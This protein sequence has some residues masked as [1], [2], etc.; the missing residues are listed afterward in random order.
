[1]S[2]NVNVTNANQRKRILMIAAKPGVSKTTGWPIGFWW[3]ELTH[4]YW[5]FTEAGYDVEIRSPGGGAL[6]TDGY[7]DPED[8]SGYSTHD[9][10]SLG[11]KKSPGH[12]ALIR[13]T[14]D[15]EGVD[16]GSRTKRGSSKTATSSSS[17]CSG[18]SPCATACLSPASSSIPVPR[19]RDS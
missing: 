19:Q 15:L 9:L 13:A 14:K 12:M 6:L 4:P 16:S 2:A 3:A 17:R 10:V 11:F 7:S 5:T 1:M 8:P 18:S